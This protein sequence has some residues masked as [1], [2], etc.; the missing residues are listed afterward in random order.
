MLVEIGHF[1]LVLA[2]LV[3]A[4]QG[5][6]PLVGAQARSR[7]LMDLA[8]P[9]A[10]LQLG[11]VALVLRDLHPCP[12]RLRFLGAERVREFEPEKPMLYKV[13]GAWGSH[14]GSMMLWVFMLALFGGLV[15]LFARSLPASLRA[16]TLAIQGLLGFGTLLFILATSESVRPSVPD[17]G[18]RPRPQPA[19][20]GSGP[21]LSPAVSLF[22]LCRLFDHLFVRDRGLARGPGRRRLGALGAA[23]GF[24]GVVRADPRHRD[25]QLVGLL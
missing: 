3:A 17:P 8:R 14:E 13:T 12:H 6:V 19:A 1:A 23:V 18:R 10:L 7:A 15:A 22:R 5:I 24:D 4:V 11:L 16:R 20:A 21:R 25:G 9:A 2:L